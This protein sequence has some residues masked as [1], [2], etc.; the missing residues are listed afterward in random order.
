[1]IL[2]DSSVWIDYFNG[3]DAPH[4]DRLDD[5][6]LTRERVIAADLI[7]CEV[8]QGFASEKDFR[9]AARVFGNLPCLELGGEDA[10]LDAAGNHR[11][12]RARGITVRSTIDTLIASFCIR[13]RIPLLHH[14]RD[15]DAYEQHLGL[16]VV[17]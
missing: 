9:A 6:L 11:K 13:H 2:V 3:V 14:D 15:F 5:L 1:V 4:T 8:L 16:R 12:L 17:R 7:V 10:V